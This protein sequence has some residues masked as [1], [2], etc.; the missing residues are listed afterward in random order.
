MSVLRLI[1]CYLRYCHVPLVLDLWTGKVSV[2]RECR[3]RG[4]V[5]LQLTF[6][7]TKPY[8]TDDFKAFSE[9][10]GELGGAQAEL[11]GLPGNLQAGHCALCALSR[12]QAP[13]PPW[14]FSVDP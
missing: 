2:G 13:V 1:T 3:E 6:V 5:E 12:I 10:C 14:C 9:Y 11:Q 7:Y 8:T 4:C